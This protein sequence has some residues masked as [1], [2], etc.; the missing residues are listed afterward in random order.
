ML[1]QSAAL[2]SATQYAMPPKFG[3]KRGTECLNTRFPLWYPAVCGIQR[4][5]EIIIH[6]LEWGSN[7]QPSRHTLVLLCLD[8]LKYS[9]QSPISYVYRRFQTEMRPSNA[10]LLQSQ[11][12]VVFL[13]LKTHLGDGRGFNFWNL[14]CNLSAAIKP[15]NPKLISLKIKSREICISRN[16][17]TDNISQW[18]ETE[19]LNIEL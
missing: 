1:R 18:W 10:R 3:D 7:P 2:S 15:T 19:W 14:W 5:T 9:T 12:G 13:S 4:E 11:V 8:N 16:T 6:S 17:Y